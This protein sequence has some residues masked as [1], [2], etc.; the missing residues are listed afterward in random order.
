MKT[1]N[2]NLPNILTISRIVITPIIVLLFL[3]PISNGIGVLCSLGIYIIASCTDFIDGHI[4]RKYN[5]VSDTG[6]LL[7]AA[8]DKFLQTSALVLVLFATEVYCPLWIKIVVLLIFLLRDA[9]ISAVRQLSASKGVIIPADMWGKV[10]SI[11]LDISIGIL[12]FFVGMVN[13]LPNGESTKFLGVT[14]GYVC[15]F[16]LTLLTVS[17]LFCLVS[18]VNYTINAWGVITG[19]GEVKFTKKAGNNSVEKEDKK[20]DAETNEIV[21]TDK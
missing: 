16:G 15:V 20:D 11:L 1:V 17:A 6:K 5:L 8:A 12:F 3:L 21:K 7:D 10:K 2:K 18:G 4:A 19:K 14:F 9:W 13:L